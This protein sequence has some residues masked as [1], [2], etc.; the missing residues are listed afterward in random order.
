MGQTHAVM[1]S[2]PEPQ[3]RHRHM[4]VRLEHYIVVIGGLDMENQPLCHYKI[5]T[6]N[7]YM[8][9]WRTHRTKGLW[10]FPKRAP[11]LYEGCVA[12]IG[13]DL[14]IFG[15][16]KIRHRQYPPLCECLCYFT[17]NSVWKLTRTPKEYFACRELSFL[18]KPSRGLPSKRRNHTGWEYAGNLWVFGGYAEEPNGYLNDHGDYT[19][20]CSNQLF[21]FDPCRETWRNPECHGSVPLPRGRHATAVLEDKVWLYGGRN[22]VTAF[23]GELYELNMCSLAWTQIETGETK[24]QARYSCTLTAISDDKL[25][26]FGGQRSSRAVFHDIWIMDLPSKTWKEMEEA[27]EPRSG[28]T[29]CLGINNKIIIIGG[30]EAQST[31]QSGTNNY[32]TLVSAPESLQQMAMMTIFIN[33]DEVPWR[34]LPRKLINI[35]GLWDWRCKLVIMFWLSKAHMILLR[36]ATALCVVK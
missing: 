28:H 8:K 26:L 29:D 22:R 30:C 33:K 17:T 6:Y 27:D 13:G 14:Y 20:G 15:G 7:I 3:R 10:T 36:L 21:C 18:L 11:A 24:P 9:R 35:L 31:R 12:A 5:W 32:T 1:P 4:A 16:R 34:C 23:D 25:V 2:G 19:N